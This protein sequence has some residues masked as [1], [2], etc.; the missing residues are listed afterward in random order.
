MCQAVRA[1]GTYIRAYGTSRNGRT[2][3][4]TNASGDLAGTP[5]VA[6]KLGDPRLSAMGDKGNGQMW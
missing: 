2:N 5:E 1:C 3:S 4:E 6:F